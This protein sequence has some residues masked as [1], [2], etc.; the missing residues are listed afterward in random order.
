MRTARVAYGGAVHTAFP[1]AHGLQLADS[2]VLAEQVLAWSGSRAPVLRQAAD[3]RWAAL[4]PQ[5]GRGF[6]P[7]RPASEA[8]AR[9]LDHRLVVCSSRPVQGATQRPTAVPAT[10]LPPPWQTSGHA[11]LLLPAGEALP[12][13]AMPARARAVAWDVGARLSPSRRAR[14]AGHRAGTL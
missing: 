13:I 2:R 11:T 5:R 4:R 3:G 6:N 7:W 10:R 9:R 8:E 12:G 1:H 14:G